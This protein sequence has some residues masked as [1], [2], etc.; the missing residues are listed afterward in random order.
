M[1]L[2]DQALSVLNRGGLVAI[3]T[4]TVYG[5]AAD[6]TNEKAIAAVF[7]AKGRPVDHP[8]LVHI[9]HGSDIFEWVRHCPEGAHRLIDHFWPGPLT[10]ILPKQP[11]V[12]DIITASEDTVGLR[13]PDQPTT[14]D[15]LKKFGKGLVAPS[16][17]RFGKIS[18]TTA[19]HVKA[20]LGDCVDFILDGGP[21]TVGIESTIIDY[22]KGYPI[23]VRPGHIQPADIEAVCDEAVRLPDH[24]AMPK[25]PGTLAAHYA[26]STP[27]TILS[28]S[29]ILQSVSEGRLQTP[30]AIMTQKISLCLQSKN[31]DITWIKMPQNTAAYA[32]QLYDTLRQLDNGQFCRIYVESLPKT[33]RWQA[34]DDRLSR[35]A[36]GSNQ[37]E[38]P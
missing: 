18:P 37:I 22:S 35:A 10:L 21:C 1:T 25:A 4:E 30:A 16:A 6:A 28:A 19:D 31:Q 12:L 3:P 33:A 32:Q 8:L 23:L 36:V 34:I 5:L 24:T 14:Q 9:A 11:A 13:C 7:H 17:N 26:P 27:L 29:E 20:E 15:L 2:I 38:T